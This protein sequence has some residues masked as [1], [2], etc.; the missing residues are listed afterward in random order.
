M[1]ADDFGAYWQ[2]PVVNVSA[3]RFNYIIHKGDEKDP[4]PDQSFIPQDQPSVWIL[5][6]D[7]RVIYKQL[8]A[9]E[10]FV[11]IALPSPGGRLWRLHQQ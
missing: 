5:S 9:A 6:G 11:T 8:G 7:L 2:V 1:T 4:G 3:S 10:K